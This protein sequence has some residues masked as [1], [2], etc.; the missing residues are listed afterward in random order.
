MNFE[1]K[2][3]QCHHISTVRYHWWHWEYRYRFSK[4][5]YS[6]RVGAP[7][8][9]QTQRTPDRSTDSSYWFEFGFAFGVV[10][11]EVW[12]GETRRK[13]ELIRTQRRRKQRTPVRVLTYAK[14][15]NYSNAV[16]KRIR[17]NTELRTTHHFCVM[18][19][20]EP[21]PTCSC[22][23]ETPAAN[24]LDTH[25]LFRGIFL[26]KYVLAMLIIWST[27]VAL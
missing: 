8:T 20:V 22:D 12:K 2:K 24:S 25:S 16:P 3:M 23:K 26:P 4:Y 18:W 17:T 10:T 1:I 21:M 11:M 13:S 15:N 7:A 27:P 14:Q 6:E 5:Q 19:F 9:T